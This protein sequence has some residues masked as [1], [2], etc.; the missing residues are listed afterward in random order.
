MNN[1]II[2]FGKGPSVLK[3]KREFVDQFDNIAICNYPVLTNHFF[4]LIKDRKIKY[5]F[6][7]CGTIDERYDNIVNKLLKIDGVYNTNRPP[8]RYQEYLKDNSIFKENIQNKSIQYFKENYNLDPNTGTMA[9]KYI[10]DTKKYNKIALVGFDNFKKGEQTY[11]YKPQYYNKKLKIYL[12]TNYTIDGKFNIIS[13]HDPN[14]TK[15]YYEDVFKKNQ[16]IEFKVITNMT[17]DLQLDNL[18]IIDK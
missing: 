13:L 18:T 3:C 2:I 10:L 7:N 6:A 14:K 12:G 11:Y 17:F 4:S 9:L 8:N 16:H 1:S 5:H 15:L